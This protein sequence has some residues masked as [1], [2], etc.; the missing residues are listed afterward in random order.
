M[1]IGVSPEKLDFALKKSETSSQKLYIHNLE[2]GPTKVVV[3]LR[4]QKYDQEITISPQELI[5]PAGL[6]QEVQIHAQASKSFKTEIEIVTLGTTQGQ[7]QITSGIVIPLEIKMQSAFNW[8]AFMLPIF[9]A[10]LLTAVSFYL[11]RKKRKLA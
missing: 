7:L 8:I 3:N 1:A 10:L 5:L 2:T 6:A 11:K 4:D 9:L